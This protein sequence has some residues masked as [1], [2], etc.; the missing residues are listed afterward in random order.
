MLR[1]LN[2]LPQVKVY[3]SRETIDA[4]R[5]TI[6]QAIQEALVEVLGVPPGKPFQHFIALDPGNSIHPLDRSD[7]YMLIEISMFSGRSRATKKHLIQTL[8]TNLTGRLPAGPA[9][10]EIILIESPPENW[11]IRGQPGDEIKL[12]YRIDV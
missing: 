4:F 11:G 7:H 2:A 8:Y 6:S 10:I 12:S 9:D 5:E 3:A 1:R